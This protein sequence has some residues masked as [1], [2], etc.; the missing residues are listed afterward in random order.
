M[1]GQTGMDRS[2]WV[3]KKRRGKRRNK[4][5]TAKTKVHLGFHMKT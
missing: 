5:E 4:G 2:N 3:G 1:G